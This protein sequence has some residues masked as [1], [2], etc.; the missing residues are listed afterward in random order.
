[1]VA[2]RIFTTTCLVLG[3]AVLIYGAVTLRQPPDTENRRLIAEYGLRGLLTITASM[4]LFIST[5][6]GAIL[7]LR[8]TREAAMR[9]QDENLATL[10]EGTLRDHEPTDKS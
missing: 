4:L 5:A 7:L 3:I 10:V 2:L 8:A 9:E 6:V 1:V